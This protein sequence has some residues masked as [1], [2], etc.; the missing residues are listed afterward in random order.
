M[1][2]TFA[3]VGAGLVGSLGMLRLLGSLLYG[4]ESSD[5]RV[6]AAVS[7]L[8]TVVALAASYV[9]ARRALRVDPVAALRWQ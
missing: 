6:L 4:V 1:W 3:G 2:W 8:L 7:L 9:P 5:L